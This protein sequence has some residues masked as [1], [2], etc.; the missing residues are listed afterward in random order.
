LAS[1]GISR[2]LRRCHDGDPSGG[3]PDCPKTDGDL[4]RGTNENTNRLLRQYLHNNADL[5]RF[6]RDHLNAVA[7]KLNHRPRRVLGW[8]IPAEAFDRV[9][10]TALRAPA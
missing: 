7:A 1:R 4:K 6:T 10:Q 3:A 9:P 5:G 8:I 2:G